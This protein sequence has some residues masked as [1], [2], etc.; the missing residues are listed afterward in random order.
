MPTRLNLGQK[1]LAFDIKLVAWI[2]YLRFTAWIP[3]QYVVKVPPGEWNVPLRYCIQGVPT[4]RPYNIRA[5]F[6][7]STRVVWASGL[8]ASSERRVHL[9]QRQAAPGSLP[10]S[11][12]TRKL[13]QYRVSNTRFNF[14]ATNTC[15]L[16][17]PYINVLYRTGTMYST[18]QVYRITSS[19]YSTFLLC[20]TPRYIRPS[21]YTSRT[22]LKNCADPSGVCEHVNPCESPKP[23]A[24]GIQWPY[25]AAY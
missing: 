16:T 15:I 5:L 12:Y 23:H 1:L 8:T 11:R 14:P 24:A 18:V 21:V 19:H 13:L 6:Y 9:L 7:Y 17:T 4:N 25:C 22:W 20:Y 2:I 10:R 3:L